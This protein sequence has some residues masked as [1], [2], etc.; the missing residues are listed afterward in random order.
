MSPAFFLRAPKSHQPHRE[1]N[2]GKGQLPGLRT[3]SCS[4]HPGDFAW[5]LGGGCSD[6]CHLPYPPAATLLRFLGRLMPALGGL[7]ERLLGTRSRGA[8]PGYFPQSHWGAAVTRRSG[9]R[10]LRLGERGERGQPGRGGKGLRRHP[11]AV[12]GFA[13]PPEPSLSTAHPAGASATRVGGHLKPRGASRVRGA[14]PAGA[15]KVKGVWEFTACLRV[16]WVGKD[17]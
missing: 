11:P 13:S 8:A 10:Q 4:E 17:F 7:W 14:R 1:G 9:A 16:M 15:G 5:V 12:P 3:G 2:P 6:P